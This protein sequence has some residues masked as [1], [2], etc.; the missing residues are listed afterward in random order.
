MVPTQS[1]GPKFAAATPSLSSA[2]AKA[3][4]LLWLKQNG[5]PVPTWDTVTTAMLEEFLLYHAVVWP[6]SAN[7]KES[8][9]LEEL[10]LQAAWPP[11]LKSQLVRMIEPLL[12]HGRLAARSSATLEDLEEASFA[13]QYESYLEL[14]GVDQVLLGIRKCWAS[15]AAPRV[16]AYLAAH[17]LSFTDLRMAVV[18][19]VMVEAECAGVAFSM[20]PVSGADHEIVIE[21]CHGLGESLVAGMVTPDRYCFDRDKNQ[22]ASSEL[23]GKK[24]ILDKN[25]IETL[26]RLCVAV[27]AKQGRPVDLEWASDGKKLWLLQS[28]PITAFGTSAYKGEWTTADMKDGGV[29]AGVCTPFM[30]SL[31]EKVFV[32]A[33]PEFYDGVGLSAAREETEPWYMV[34]FGRPYWN[35]GHI[36]GRLALLPGYNER[37]FDEDLG[38]APTYEGDGV[39]TTLSLRSL[40][41]GL[42]VLNLMQKS[43]AH[44]IQV[45]QGL[46][47]SLSARLE[48]LEA[49]TLLDMPDT[50]LASAL[51]NLLSEDYYQCECAYFVTIYD[52][53]NAQTLFQEKLAGLVGKEKAKSVG[54]PLIGGLENLSHMRPTRE[55]FS[56][57]SSLSLDPNCVAYFR[58]HSVSQ[59]VDAYHG[60]DPFPGA[61]PI[62]AYLD[63]WGWMAPRT[64]EILQKRWHED[65]TPLLESLKRGL[66]GDHRAQKNRF[67]KAEEKQALAYLEALQSMEPHFERGLP[68]LRNHR[69]RGFMNALK[70]TRGLLWWREEMRM[71]STRMYAQVRRFSLAYGQRLCSKGFLR[72]AS[73]V[74]FLKYEEIMQLL[75]GA[76]AIDLCDPIVQRR[77]LVY[78]GFRNFDNPDEIGTRC[79]G[80]SRLTPAEP[81]D[82]EGNRAASGIAGSAG[83]YTGIARV[84]DSVEQIGRLQ[85]GDILVTR[86]TDP[87]W[88]MAFAHLG[89]VV[90]ETGGVLSHAAVIAREYGFPAV[91]ALKHAMQIIPDG[92]TITVDGNQGT[93]HLEEE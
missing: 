2:G 59:I 33:T 67:R 23:S 90:T 34:A 70:A 58:S 35:V 50:E 22:V 82:G 71:L 84:I 32:G 30:A 16:S 53:S 80:T 54:L 8:E 91:L 6:E 47:G 28:R 38:I 52:N 74:F 77:R 10:F 93:V 78:Q 49:C 4:S 42:K 83:R 65:P 14:E 87:G 68:G 37:S 63:R 72:E 9:A 18:L 48:F 55:E 24:A 44:R 56:L 92:A 20:N 73:D 81:L 79:E 60:G 45:N 64:L 29:S 40:W 76:M 36:K 26:V 15:L 46:S 31:Y 7:E 62:Q 5:F 43:F 41:K 12:R 11:A 3:D 85:A 25:E 19:Q 21:A 66:E 88:T 1:P 75:E 27:Q 57:V 89:A 86:F 13:G 51:S 17:D 69:R 61:E 39:T